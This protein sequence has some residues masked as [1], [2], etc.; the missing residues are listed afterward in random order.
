MIPSLLK[1]EKHFHMLGFG[2]KLDSLPRV[3]LIG[4]HNVVALPNQPVGISLS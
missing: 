4:D 3:L 2:M 1:G